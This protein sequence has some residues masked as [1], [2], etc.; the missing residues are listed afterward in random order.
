M[1]RLMCSAIALVA[2]ATTLAAT[3][4]PATA[5]VKGDL[6][7]VGE[8]PVAGTYDFKY[9]NYSEKMRLCMEDGYCEFLGYRVAD[10]TV[11]MKLHTYRLIE[12]IDDYDYYVLDVDVE[13]TGRGGSS[14]NGWAQVFVENIAAPG[15]RRVRLVDY[16]DTKSI[17]AKEPDCDTLNLGI[18]HSVGPASASLDWGSVEFC[19]KAASYE[20]ERREGANRTVFMAHHAREVA[21]FSSQRIVKVP[22]GKRPTFKVTIHLPSDDCTASRQGRCTKFVNDTI[23]YGYVIGTTG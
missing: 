16:A 15:G 12:G 21:R 3:T 19:D 1:K 20:V 23:T 13:N 2:V 8:Q 9:K 10:G 7:M 18:G 5:D 4:T 14:K 6:R 22:A 17:S 11:H